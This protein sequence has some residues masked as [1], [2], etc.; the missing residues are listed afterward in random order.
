MGAHAHSPK[1]YVKVWGILIVL[2]LISVF[3]PM[4]EIKSLTM[5]TAFG[6]AIV[7]ALIVAK[8]FMHINL[9]RKYITYIILTMLLMTFLFYAGTVTDVLYESGQNWEKTM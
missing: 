4:L 8:N 5:I 7:K 1:D 2:F 9:E 3:G 6:I